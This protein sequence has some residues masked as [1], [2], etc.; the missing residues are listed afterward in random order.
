V[1]LSGGGQAAVLWGFEEILTEQLCQ[2]IALLDKLISSEEDTHAQPSVDRHLSNIARLGGYLAPASD[3][4][5]GNTIMWQRASR[6]T[7]GFLLAKGG[8]GN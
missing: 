5:P 2:K 6:L 4:P 3:P 8:V 7:N 1:T